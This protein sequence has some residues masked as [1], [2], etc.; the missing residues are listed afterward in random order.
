MEGLTL[1][2]AKHPPVMEERRK[3]QKD[4]DNCGHGQ[5]KWTDS[6]MT[7]RVERDDSQGCQA[8]VQLKN[9]NLKRNPLATFRNFPVCTE[10][11][12]E[13]GGGVLRQELGTSP[14]DSEAEDGQPSGCIPHN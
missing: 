14:A 6:Q 12:M 5:E 8:T 10:R 7:L 13:R 1:N 11:E 3:G 2:R 9:I 4:S